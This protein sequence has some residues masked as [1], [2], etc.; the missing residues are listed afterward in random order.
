MEPEAAKLDPDTDG[1]RFERSSQIH[2]KSKEENSPHFQ[3][4]E[5]AIAKELEPV[6]QNAERLRSLVSHPRVQRP[7]LVRAC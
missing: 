5:A 7:F 4:L 3:I 1:S 2:N 6:Y